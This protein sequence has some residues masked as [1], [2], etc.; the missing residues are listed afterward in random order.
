[1]RKQSRDRERENG[2]QRDGEGKRQGGGVGGGRGGK[3]EMGWSGLSSMLSVTVFKCF[4]LL[5]VSFICVCVC[6]SLLIAIYDL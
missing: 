1:M 6:F 3:W 4:K 5:F 2:R